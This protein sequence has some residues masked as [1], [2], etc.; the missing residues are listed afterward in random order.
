[1]LG[2]S[3]L[4]RAGLATL[5]RSRLAARVDR[6]VAPWLTAEQL[7]FYLDHPNTRALRGLVCGEWIDHPKLA[8]VEEVSTRAGKLPPAGIRRSLRVEG[9]WDAPIQYDDWTFRPCG[10]F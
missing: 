2:I 6:L 1:M 4:T 7:G 5:A 10:P 8:R 3:R 9:R